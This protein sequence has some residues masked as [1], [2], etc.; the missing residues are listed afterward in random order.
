MHP[1]S[2]RSWKPTFTN[3]FWCFSVGTIL[4]IISTAC[5]SLLRDPTPPDSD[6]STHRPL[7]AFLR[8]Y[9]EII[10]SDRNLRVFLLSEWMNW[11]SAM[12]STFIVFYAVN[13]FGQRIAA[14][15]NFTRFL[16]MILVVPLA[17]FIVS[18]LGPRK[19]IVMFYVCAIGM[20]IPLALPPS[21]A[22]ILASTFLLGCSLVFRVNYL[23]HFIAALCPD[24][25]K[26]GYYALCSFAV[27]PMIL[28]GP[29]IGGTIVKLMGGTMDSY[30][31]VFAIS[32]APLLVGL[33]LV[34]KVLKDPVDVEP[35]VDAVP[36]TALKRMTIFND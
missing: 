30:R 12:G 31:L 26:S 27:G 35:A 21:R 14:Q 18:R 7:G 19:A 17:H 6:T 16:A 9:L 23:F 20:F 10:R 36:R 8:E 3:Y 29:F 2:Q 34:W 25:N 32:I 15:C 11:L 24:A 13:I 33:W 28:V 1:A 22:S 5:Y 4:F